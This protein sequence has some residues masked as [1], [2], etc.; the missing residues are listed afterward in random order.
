[1]SASLTGKTP[2]STDASFKWLAH[3][4]AEGAFPAD[5]E[6]PQKLFKG[7]GTE[8]PISFTATKVFVNGVEYVAATLR[9]DTEDLPSD[10]EKAQM[11]EN[12]GYELHATT[13]LANAS[14][15]A[16]GIPFYNTTSKRY[17]TTTSAS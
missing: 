17:E 16:I 8:T 14:L 10:A 1:M 15:G 5:G 12:L 11:A 6:T 7:D 3:F 9:K 13:S 4:G 2:G